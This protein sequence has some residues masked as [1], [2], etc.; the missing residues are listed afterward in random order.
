MISTISYDT[1]LVDL[2]MGKGIAVE[3]KKRFGGLKELVAQKK[4]VGSSIFWFILHKFRGGFD[5]HNLMNNNRRLRLFVC[6]GSACV[7][8]GHQAQLLG[9]HEYYECTYMYNLS[10][11]L[12]ANKC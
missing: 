4:G 3:F 12:F 6:G 11:S 7:L 2:K 10:A 5:H 1:I 9:T 8:L